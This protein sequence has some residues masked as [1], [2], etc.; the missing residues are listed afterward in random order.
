MLVGMRTVEV[1]RQNRGWKRQPGDAEEQ[2]QIERDQ[3]IVF[4]VDETEQS[5]VIQPHDS[6][7]HEAGEESQIRWPERQQRLPK[8][9]AIGFGNL[10]RQNQ[11]RDGDGEH[12]VAERLDARRLVVRAFLGTAVD[13]AHAGIISR[14]R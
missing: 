11:Q 1:I 3:S 9:A 5:V 2:Q 8:R 4:L 7:R 14:T 12:A 13:R 6:D 10:D